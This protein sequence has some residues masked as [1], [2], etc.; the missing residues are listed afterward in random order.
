MI[1]VSKVDAIDFAAFPVGKQVAVMVRRG[2]R[3]WAVRKS[4]KDDYSDLAEVLAECTQAAVER[5][6][7]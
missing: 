4:V 7:G 5:A 1:D 2:D 3:R 6:N